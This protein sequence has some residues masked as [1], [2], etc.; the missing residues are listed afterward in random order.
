[1]IATM[2]KHRTFLVV[3]LAFTVVAFIGSSA[4]GWGSYSYGSRA[5]A[6][7]TVGDEKISR[8]EFTRYYGQL[9][10]LYAGMLDQ[11]LNEAQERDIQNRALESMIAEALFVAYARDIGLRVSAEEISETIMNDPRFQVDGAFVDKKIYLDYLKNIG[12]KPSSYEAMLEKQLLVAKLSEALKL[13][14]AQSEKE[15]I[16]ATRYG[17]D[18]ISYKIINAPANVKVSQEEA[19]SYYEA[20]ALQFMGEPSYDISFIEILASEQN[21][22][23]EEAQSYYERA[24]SEFIGQDGEVKAYEEVKIEALNAAKLAKARRAALSAKIAWRDNQLAPQTLKSVEFR[25]DR[26]PV[27]VMQALESAQSLEV[28]GPFETSGGFVIAKIDAR[29][30]AEPLPFDKARSAVEEELKRQKNVEYLKAESQKQ[31][32]DFKG[33]TTDF[34]SRD[35]YDKVKG[36][37]ENEA[38]IFLE[39]VFESKESEGAVELT[40]KAVVYR[41]VE[42]KL[43]EPNKLAEVD[44]RLSE[45]VSR[46][47]IEQVRRSLLESLQKRYEIIGY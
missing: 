3:V 39:R 16:A 34:L 43:F 6:V 4:V 5:G 19:Q 2:Q 35:D 26:F 18:R 1:M 10:E 27:E 29:R 33:E 31:L 11:P 23:E 42:Q 25:N 37:S 9:R 28:A 13:P 7:A 46:L 32:P 36:L 22:T 12:M 17:V 45:D 41:I 38:E 40:D 24:K 20:N 14:V 21:A 30:A 44:E 15:T 47:K 8:E